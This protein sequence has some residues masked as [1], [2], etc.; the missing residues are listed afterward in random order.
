MSTLGRRLEKRATRAAHSFAPTSIARA[1]SRE[2][3]EKANR[4]QEGTM[5]AEPSLPPFFTS[6]RAKTPPAHHLADVHTRGAPYSSRRGPRLAIA[7]R[8][9]VNNARLSSGHRSFLDAKIEWL[10][11]R[12]LQQN[13]LASAAQ[14]KGQCP[15]CRGSHGRFLRLYSA[16]SSSQVFGTGFTTVHGRHQPRPL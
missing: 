12:N 13:D 10:V 2:A 7:R 8:T 16:G 6:H 4:I 11:S 14:Q 9:I 15:P 3:E 1:I 5:W